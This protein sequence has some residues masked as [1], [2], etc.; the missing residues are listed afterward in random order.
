MLPNLKNKSSE[1]RQGGA[2]LDFTKSHKNLSTIDIKVRTQ[3]NIMKNTY[4]N[5]A[6]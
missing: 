2:C 1:L 6:A 3:D 5:K 4:F